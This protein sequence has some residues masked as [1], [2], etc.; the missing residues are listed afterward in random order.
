[1]V[2]GCTLFK[3]ATIGG[4]VPK[5]G[6]LQEA[7]DVSTVEDMHGRQYPIRVLFGLGLLGGQGCTLPHPK[8]YE[9]LGLG[10][11]GLGRYPHLQPMNSEGV[12]WGRG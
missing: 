8:L 6:A 9:F 1:M 2:C 4:V 5:S 12:G 7:E 3:T 10:G 11:Y